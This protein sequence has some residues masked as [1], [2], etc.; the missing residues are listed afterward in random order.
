MIGDSAYP[1]HSWLMK[2]FSFSSDLTT[3][4]CTY[5]YRISRARIVAENA[6]GR[7]KACWRRLMKRNDMYIHNVP[8]VAAAVCVL[9]KHM[10]D[11][12]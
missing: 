10:R 9:H 7:P 1:I 5:N 6:F 11:L 8:V 2:P 3:Q 12:S 4:Q